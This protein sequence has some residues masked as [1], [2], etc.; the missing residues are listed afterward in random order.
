DA[1]EQCDLGAQNGA[2]GS[3][4]TAGC[5]FAASTVA[6]SVPGPSDCFKAG[7]CPG[8]AT[9]CVSGGNWQRADAHVCRPSAGICDVPEV[10]A[11][12]TACPSDDAHNGTVCDPWSGTRC[13][14]AVT[15]P[16]NTLATGEKLR[17]TGTCSGN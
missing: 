13:N 3:C 7:H 1:G 6:C 12:G 5:T 9:A 16:T 15:C 17:S 14:G 11:G 4:C 10:C 8:N 2:T